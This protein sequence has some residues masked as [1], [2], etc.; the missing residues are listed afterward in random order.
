M[1]PRP[2]RQFYGDPAPITVDGDLG[3]LVDPWRRHRRRFVERLSELTD[4][5]WAAPS[6]CEGWTVQDVISHLSTADGFWVVS[7]GQAAAGEPSSYLIDFDPTAAPEALVAPTRATAPAQVLAGF[8]TGTDAFVAAVEAVDD[9]AWADMGESPVGHVPLT[10]VLA[11]ALW[12]SWLHERDIFVPLGLDVPVEP[13][14]LAVATWYSLAIGA[15]E[16]GLVGDARPV[17]PGL[18]A[19]LPLHVAADRAVVLG[20]G[21]GDA[22]PAGSAVAFVEGFTGR[23]PLVDGALP[24]ALDAQLRRAAGIL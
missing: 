12:D 10:L 11:H 8:R 4:E 5:Q 15:L 22:T 14:E 18:S 17:G 13:D 7:L 21:R 6:R 19:P 1:G 2:L 16:G 20:P 23:A 3:P 9:G 24:A